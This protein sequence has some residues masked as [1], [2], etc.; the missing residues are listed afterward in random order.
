MVRNQL[1]Q[2]RVQCGFHISEVVLKLEDIWVSRR[3]RWWAVLTA[4]FLG[5]VPLRAFE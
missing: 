3:T 4:S 5:Q 1:E 2:F